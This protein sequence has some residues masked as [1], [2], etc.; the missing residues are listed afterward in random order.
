MHTREEKMAAFGRVLDVMDELREKCPWDRILQLYI[1]ILIRFSSNN[2][3]QISIKIIGKGKQK[4]LS[5]YYNGK[6]P[7]KIIIN[8]NIYNIYYDIT[9]N[10]VYNLSQQENNITMIWNGTLTNINSMFL[11]L[12][13]LK[14]IDFSK[15]NS[16]NI[17][18]MEYLF[19]HCTKLVSL[20]LSNFDTALVTS[21]YGM[22]F[23]CN[24]LSLLNLTN[25]DTSNVVTM[26]DMFS[27]C[28]K[29]TSLNLNNF[30]TSKVTDMDHMFCDCSS[31]TALYIDN[32]N[33][34][35]VTTMTG[36]FERCYNL[37]SL[38][39]T[40]FDTSAVTSLFATFSNCWSLTSLDLSNF[41]TSSATVM[42]VMFQGCKSLTSLD[43]SNFETSKVTNMEM[44]FQKCNNLK[45][46]NLSNF[47]TPSLSVI[48][49]MFDNCNS[50]E[51]LDISNFDISNIEDISYL[52]SECYNLTSVNLNKF[53]TSS[54]KYMTN[55]FE[56]CISLK[57]LNLSNFDTSSVIYMN[58][59]FKGCKNLMILDLNYLNF[60]NVIYFPYIFDDINDN[61]SFCIK[62]NEDSQIFKDL[63]SSYNNN[64][65][66]QCYLNPKNKIIFDSYKCISNCLNEPSHSY[67]YNN[68]CYSSC[69][70]GTK[71][72]SDNEKQCED[73][74]C[75]NNY[76]NYNQTACIDKIPQGY[77]L[78]DS[79][80]RT[81]D[82]CD[83]KCGNC[84]IESNKYN[85]CVSCNNEN[86]YYEKLND[87]LNNNPFINC[88]NETPEGYSLDN[89]IYKP[90]Y[91]S[92]KNCA[93]FGNESNNKCISCKIGY[94]FK[95]DFENDT[96]CYEICEHYYFFD[97]KK[98]YYCTSND[99]CPIEYNKLIRDK[100]KCVSNCSIDN[101][102]KYE[103]NNTCYEYFPNITDNSSQTQ[104]LFN[105]TLTNEKQDNDTF[106]TDECNLK[107]FLN[108]KCKI[109]NQNDKNNEA[110]LKD[111][112][113]YNIRN[114]IMSGDSIDE[115]IKN[116]YNGDK[117]DL[118]IEDDN[119]IYQITST[120]SQE[121]NNNINISTINLGECGKILKKENNIS[122][123][124]SLLIFKI[125]YFQ[126]GSSIPIIGYEFYNPL[127]KKQM[128]LD[129]CKN[130]N[131]KLNIP[132]DIKEDIL[133]KYD[134]E[135]EYY[136]DVCN[137]ST[138][139][140]GTDILLNDRHN[141]FNTN[142]M[143]LCQK[144]CNYSEYNSDNKKAV[145]IFRIK[146]EQVVISDLM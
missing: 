136:T 111:E 139:E 118:I 89:N 65:N 110:K 98:K 67:E 44:M 49:G 64:N 127:T 80:L 84:S 39:I 17:V 11:E 7:Y 20:D 10:S 3:N 99:S 14:E 104:Y 56:N 114:E 69:P 71:I 135:N 15:F 94:D 144:N 138:T 143:S 27:G 62:G 8:E 79:Y 131:I 6:L 119:I 91:Y 140:S 45:K 146:N 82:K 100:R 46:L 96:N 124:Q 137:P 85:L 81:I 43:L 24:E 95:S 120:E 29:L 103:Y 115:L 35:K 55:M 145:C 30:D 38:N 36:M 63:L 2:Y 92:C 107:N 133:Y 102:Y 76:Y 77:Y 123:N 60:S 26:N 141:E 13:N 57:S 41:N 68:M 113:I 48:R 128:N 18:D 59:T 25:F 37:T 87:P 90:C 129:S 21:M 83:I 108:K 116:L 88:Y 61:I 112:I 93:G 75:K 54:V 72:K 74:L 28:N 121:S 1:I 117:R 109:N 73:I 4:I 126:E 9:N 40:H 34:S 22:F 33:T 101:E 106:I 16:S 125:D 53:N 31:F 58:K 42:L 66:C 5:D 105:I 32:F 86:N 97:S 12:S 70:N 47:R 130:T 122:Q 78:N 19:G 51:T 132:V 23:Q 142:N 134:P 50:L 52:F